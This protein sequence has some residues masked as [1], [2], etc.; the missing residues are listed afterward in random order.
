[1]ASGIRLK[2]RPD[3]APDLTGTSVV[4]AAQAQQG[5]LVADEATREWHP[6]N[7]QEGGELTSRAQDKCGDKPAVECF[8]GD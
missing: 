7:S 6:L 1:M 2:G 5:H 4:S 8:P 3:A